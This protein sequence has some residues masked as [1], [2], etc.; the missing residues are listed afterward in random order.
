MET[1]RGFE[2]WQNCYLEQVC[3]R[4]DDL[5]RFAFALC[6]SRHRAKALVHKVCQAAIDHPEDFYQENQTYTRLFA[7]L[8]SLISPEESPDASENHPIAAMLQT[9]NR[10]EKIA[11]MSLD[12]MGLTEKECCDITQW[13]KESLRNHAA[14]G[15]EKILNAS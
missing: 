13:T 1:S 6:F 3:P 11:V 7:K 2:R 8:L 12:V 14:S 10:D 15:R 5:L 9:L 4:A